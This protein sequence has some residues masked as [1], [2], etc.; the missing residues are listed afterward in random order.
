MTG[1]QTCAL[2]I[3]FPVTIPGEVRDID[4]EEK[5]QR[6]R[7]RL[8]REQQ[9]K[10]EQAE[11]EEQRKRE[12]AARKLAEQRKR[13]VQDYADALNKLSE[14]QDTNEYEAA[15]IRVRIIQK[16]TVALQ[17]AQ[18]KSV[19]DLNARYKEIEKDRLGTFKAVGRSVAGCIVTGK[20]IGR[21]HV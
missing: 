15:L 21:A 3:C 6:E 7:E 17:I 18:N 20:Q 8:N 19:K 10:A 12:Q 2:P 1:V 5:A 11:Q 16:E 9:R 4:A 14:A 13:I